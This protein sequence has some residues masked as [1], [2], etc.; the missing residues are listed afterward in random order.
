MMH[1]LPLSL[2]LFASPAEVRVFD[3]EHV[4]VQSEAALS[5]REVIARHLEIV[6]TTLRGEPPAGLT[7]TQQRARAALLDELHAYRV[8]GEFPRNLDFAQRRVPYFIDDRG[9]ACAVGHLMIASGAEALAREIATYENNDFLADIDHP[10]VGAWLAAHGLTA[11]EAAWIQPSYTP[12]WDEPYVCGVDGLTYECRD[13]AECAG[14]EVDYEGACGFETDTDGNVGDPDV[15]REDV[16][17][18]GKGCTISATPPGPMVA[19]FGVAV[20]VLGV[21]LGRRRDR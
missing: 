14:V 19:L 5:E 1:A 17:D 4:R 8:R 21:S 20:V 7:E 10:G 12:C 2:V 16:C 11:A 18:D 3:P 6:E 15:E 13:A 9:T